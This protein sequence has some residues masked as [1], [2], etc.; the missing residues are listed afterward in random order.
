MAALV[1]LAGLCVP[2]AAWAQPPDFRVFRTTVE[3]I[4][5]Q[6]RLGNSVGPGGSCFVCHT[7]V[8]SRL[9]LQPLPPGAIGWTEEQSRLNYAAVLRLIVPGDPLKSR[10]LMHPLSAEAG[11]DPSHAGGKHWTSQ[12]AGEFQTIAAWVRTV[13]PG[14]PPPAVMLD[15]EA[16]RTKIQ[17]ILLKKRPGSARCATCHARASSFL[18]VPV[19]AG[20]AWT[21]E[22]SRKNFESITG[23][24]LVV[25]GDPLSSRLLMMPL[26]HEAGGDPFHPGGKHWESPKDPEWQTLA[27]WV[28]DGN[29]PGR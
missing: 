24:M 13:S 28:R 26:A 11:G 19:P 17:P 10:L 15:Y 21:E 8:T 29:P 18:E 27:A 16:F 25:P 20:A 7:R 22:Q 9:K 5:L 14:T 12:E 6:P 3:P 23:R 2:R 4:F 1:L